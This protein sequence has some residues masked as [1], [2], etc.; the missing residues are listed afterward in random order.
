M[1]SPGLGPGLHLHPKAI[2]PPLLAEVNEMVLV[3][4]TVLPFVIG[5]ILGGILF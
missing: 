5:L 3:M 2:F 1:P 4:L